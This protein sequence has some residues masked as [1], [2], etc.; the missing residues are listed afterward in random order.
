PLWHV[1]GC[2]HGAQAYRLVHQGDPRLRRVPQQGEPGTRCR[3]RQGDARGIL[4]AAP[5]AGRRM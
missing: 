4:R 3:S 2:Q 1:H 5:D